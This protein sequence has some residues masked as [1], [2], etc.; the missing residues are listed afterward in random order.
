MSRYTFITYAHDGL[1]HERRALQFA[2]RLRAGGV[3]AQIDQY[4]SHPPE[5]WPKWME[6]QF[7]KADAIL[8]VPSRKHLERYQQA[9]GVGS[10]ARF[11]AAI[12]SSILSKNG[13]SF[14]KV[15]VTSL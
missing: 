8:I 12:L 7:V 1:S 15:G 9:D 10:G 11:E 2:N 14:E 5:G 6:S 13:V 4:E 3:D